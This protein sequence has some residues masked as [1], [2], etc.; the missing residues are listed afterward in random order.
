MSMFVQLAQTSQVLS[1]TALEEASRQGLR[2]ADI[3]HL[4]LALVLSDQ[5]AGRVLRE[6]GIGIEDA[7]RAVRDQH[8]AQLASLGVRAALPDPG[9]IVFHETDGYELKQ[10][11]ADLIRRAGGKSRDGSAA[12]VLRELVAEP[13]G[14]IA[15]ILHRLDVAPDEVLERLDRSVADAGVPAPEPSLSKGQASGSQ[16]TFVPGPVA[17]V[18]D[19]LA[20]PGRVPEWEVSAGEIELSGQEA[21]RGAVWE[22]RA[23]EEFPDGKPLNIK[24]PYRRRRIELVTAERPHRVAWSFVYPDAPQ[25]RPFRTEFTLAPTTGGTRVTITTSWPRHTGWRRLVGVPLRPLQKLTVWLR[26]FQTGSAV[27]RAFR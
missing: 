18:W 25:S 16:G 6:I 13:S 8:D 20:D 4:F 23:A 22:G 11:A 12:A 21:R 5:V 9:R 15:D 17:Q 27:S 19:F 7:R 14:L 2:E 10:R 26:L 3:E 24:P 1:L